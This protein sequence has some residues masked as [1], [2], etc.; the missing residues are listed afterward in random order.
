MAAATRLASTFT[1]RSRLNRWMLSPAWCSSVPDNP[2]TFLAMRPAQDTA[3][4]EARS[5]ASAD[6]WTV[7]TARRHRG[8]QPVGLRNR[9]RLLTCCAAQFNAGVSGDDGRRECLVVYLRL[10]QALQML[11]QLARDS[12][13]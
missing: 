13:T 4:A 9:V 1:T 8:N 11:T 10:R 6:R 12:G 7:R 5:I 3:S 2:V